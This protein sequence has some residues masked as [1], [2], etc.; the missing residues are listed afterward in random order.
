[1]SRIAPG[2]GAV[3]SIESINS[4]NSIN[5]ILSNC[6]SIGLTTT[7]KKMIAQVGRRG[8]GG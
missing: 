4:I 6:A 5:S 8:G 1:M 3:Y 2:G 7:K